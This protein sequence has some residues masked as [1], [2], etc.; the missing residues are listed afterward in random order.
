VSLKN[1][2][3][4]TK[5]TKTTE[6]LFPHSSF[7]YRI[8]HAEKNDNKICWFTHSSHVQKYIDRSQLKA[9]TYT[10]D[11]H[12]AY[13]PLEIKT[14]KKVKLKK[15]QLFADLDTYVKVSEK[16]KR[17]RKAA[18]APVLTPEKPKRTRKA[19]PAPSRSA[20]KAP[21]KASKGTDAP[22]APKRRPRSKK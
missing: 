1:I 5:K 22:E 3:K 15:Q 7:P 12:P 4:R 13:A 20:R 9:G 2:T 10:V 6:E 14:E 8:E 11:V 17:T 16:P 21:V 18:T 19:P